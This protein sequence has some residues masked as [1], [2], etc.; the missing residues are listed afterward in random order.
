MAAPFEARLFPTGGEGLS[1]SYLL[2][3]AYDD[4]TGRPLAGARVRL[5]ASGDLLPGAVPS[6]Q[7]SPP[8]A[9]T[10]TDSRGR[11]QIVDEVSV[12]RYTLVVETEGYARVVRR[13]DLEPAVGTV[14][15]DARL[16]PL[17]AET[18]PLDPVA[19]VRIADA[20]SPLLVL[21]ADPGAVPGLD[22]LTVHLAPRSP[23]ALPDFL[24][25][26]WTPL[27]AADLALEDAA[28]PLPDGEATPFASGGV[29]LEL[30]LPDWVQPT[31]TLYAVR[32]HLAGGAWLT[33]DAPELVEGPNSEPVARVTLTGPGSVAVVVPD[34]GATAPP[35]PAVGAGSILRGVARPSSL[36]ELDGELVLDPPVIPATG[37]SRADVI[38]RSA[39]GESP[40]PSG[41]AVQ[42]YLEERLLL[43][44]GGEVVESPFVAD[45]LLY[46][47]R[48]D[49]ALIGANT[50]DSVGAV[51]FIVS[52]SERAS[53]VLLEVGYEDITL[54]PFP[55]EL[56]RGQVLGA[57]GGT[58]T[59]PDGVE[60]SL[61]EGALP[62]RTAVSASL[63]TDDELAGLAVVPGFD[64][65]AAVRLDFGGR[66]LARPAA[67]S[68]DTPESTPEA[69]DGD[70]RLVLTE[71][72][73]VAADG[74]GSYNRLAARVGRTEGAGNSGRL[75]AAPEN[76][77]SGLPL[78]GIVREGTYL[79]LSAQAS[80][81]YATGF[82]RAPNGL[83]L[84]AARVTADNLGTADLSVAGGRYTA[85]VP[86]APGALLTAT[87]PTLD[88]TGSAEIPTV[89]PADIITL[90]ITVTPVPP[91]LESV[92]PPNGATTDILAGTHVSVRFSKA[93]DAATVG[94]GTL[95]LVLA[96]RN[97][98]PTGAVV[99]GSVSLLLGQHRDR[100]RAGRT[101][102][103]RAQLRG[104]LLGRGHRGRGNPLHRR[105]IRLALPCFRRGAARRPDPPRAFPHP[106]AGRRRR[107]TLRR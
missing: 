7:E 27:A 9:E 106:P 102:G 18:E 59:S 103:A 81:A 61:P 8:L 71:L 50:A 14:A 107:R 83:G 100:L 54:Y 89:Q 92:E 44:G 11:Y 93:L 74:R 41:I 32:Y 4:T 22:P 60:L 48:L 51:D 90:D 46:R 1:G 96:D 34:E 63:L 15:F 82:V 97:G 2:G 64:T 62:S 19:G 87:H 94:P 47:P 85:M 49:P 29:H 36:P 104:P 67:L 10:A 68:L 6:G 23:Q 95:S 25:L 53:A 66:V 17:T 35:L 73:E 3:E 76:F 99:R 57:A 52:P 39:D 75:R 42:A 56:E 31:D 38:A 24:P 86:T 98:N 33:L 43:S 70:P 40:W 84:A 105:P 21:D 101:A 5:F 45:L 13:L 88:E 26:G 91:V 58:V 12:G 30:P 80:I 65:L 78:I 28:G 79:V 69:I 20:E 55:E 77:D 72:V 37:R 16:T